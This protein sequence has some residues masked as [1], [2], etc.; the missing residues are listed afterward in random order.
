MIPMRL[1]SIFF[2]VQRP[3]LSAR[4]FGGHNNPRVNKSNPA[5]R[6]SMQAHRLSGLN[7]PKVI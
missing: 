3:N 2:F 6:P 5:F 7:I 4:A 1:E